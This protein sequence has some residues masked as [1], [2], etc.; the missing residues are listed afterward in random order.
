M[1]VNTQPVRQQQQVSRV[2]Q[3]STAARGK[4]VS[5]NRLIRTTASDTNPEQQPKLVKNTSGQTVNDKQSDLLL[6]DSAEQPIL[7]FRIVR[8]FELEAKT[9]FEMQVIPTVDPSRAWI[10]RHR[11]SEFRTLHEQLL[12]YFETGVGICDQSSD[13][14]IKSAAQQSH[15]LTEKGSNTQIGLQVQSGGINLPKFK[16]KMKSFFEGLIAIE[17]RTKTL[18]D[19][20]NGLIA[21]NNRSQIK[22]LLQCPHFD[23]FIDFISQ[24]EIKRKIFKQLQ[25]DDNKG[26][27]PNERVRKA[28]SSNFLGQSSDVPKTGI[29]SK[30]ALA[31]KTEVDPEPKSNNERVK[32]L[33]D[34]LEQAAQ[35]SDFEERAKVLNYLDEFNL[36]IQND[37]YTDDDLKRIFYGNGLTQ[38][39]LLGQMEN[40]RL[41]KSILKLLGR[42]V[43]TEKNLSY[44]SFEQ[45][46]HKI[47]RQKL[48]DCN[49]AQFFGT[50]SEEKLVLMLLDCYAKR[51]IQTDRRTLQDPTKPPNVFANPDDYDYFLSIYA[52]WREKSLRKQQ[53]IAQVT[54]AP[55]TMKI[56][57][58]ASF[59]SFSSAGR[60]GRG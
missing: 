57:K 23:E 33:L 50:A 49:F 29:Y 39:G 13:K 52:R 30:Q 28:Q 55:Q 8:N 10:V 41:A 9:V 44:R 34:K 36:F 3:D 16:A 32:R 46:I 11:H 54:T 4:Q 15:N 56:Q 2:P 12:S 43:D 58:N 24:P 40:P 35:L 17:T 21:I 5:D 18:Q 51:S 45:I 59:S 1:Q 60:S 53:Q 48:I 31:S 42:I 37:A 14:K 19:Y 6:N 26:M 47:P 7:L 27:Q 38:K 25:D 20:M 22:K